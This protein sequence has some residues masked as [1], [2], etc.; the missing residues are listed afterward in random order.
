MRDAPRHLIE[1]GEHGDRIF[2]ILGVGALCS[3]HARHGEKDEK[4]SEAG[5]A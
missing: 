4:L 1:G 3:E 2:H 5:A